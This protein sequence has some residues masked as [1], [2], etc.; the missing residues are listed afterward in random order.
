M[1]AAP[2]C[3]AG[4][5]GGS[6][7][8]CWCSNRAVRCLRLARGQALLIDHGKTFTVATGL[9][10]SATAH[11]GEPFPADE[12]PAEIRE[13]FDRPEYIWAP[14]PEHMPRWFRA[15]GFA[16]QVLRR[17]I[18]PRDVAAPLPRRLLARAYWSSFRVVGGCR[19]SA[20]LGLPVQRALFRPAPPDVPSRCPRAA[21]GGRA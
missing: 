9:A 15:W 18:P 16:A 3:V 5:T 19:E 6:R 21:T 1:A 8:G 17:E 10:L 13:L 7:R 14:G 2:S 12:G 4:A 11:V 20:C